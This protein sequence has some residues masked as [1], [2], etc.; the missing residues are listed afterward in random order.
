MLIPTFSFAESVCSI[1]QFIYDPSEENDFKVPTWQ[2]EIKDKITLYKCKKNDVL[3]LTVFPPKGKNGVNNKNHFVSEGVINGI[4][5]YKCN[6]NKTII[7]D[8]DGLMHNLVC[9]LK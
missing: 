5:A 2:T 1:T 6:F 9:I 7:T 3:E 4:A 8:T